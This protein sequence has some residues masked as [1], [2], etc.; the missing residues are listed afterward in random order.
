MF[1]HFKIRL[2]DLKAGHY[3]RSR[4]EPLERT[5]LS[6]VYAEKGDSDSV[7]EAAGFWIDGEIY[8]RSA[9]VEDTS[10]W[11][12][13]E[14]ARYEALGPHPCIL[15]CLGVELLPNGKEAWALRLERAAHGNLRDYIE[16]NKPP[17]MARRIRG[18][19]YFART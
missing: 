18:A 16:R 19:A 2:P 7:L 5:G 15:A 4:L 3:I 1:R 12:K 9:F 6:I 17:N 10:N 14:A 11:F 13:R 8:D